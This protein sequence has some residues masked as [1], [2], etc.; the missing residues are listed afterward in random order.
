MTAEDRSDR[1]GAEPRSISTILLERVCARQPEA[2]QRL[3]H[4]YAPVVH[5]W[6]RELGV[7]PT[8]VADV[9]QD[10]FAGVLAD[11]GRFRR[12]RPSDSFGAWLR[13]ITRRRVIDHF[14]RGSDEA[15]AAGGTDAYRRMLSVPESEDGSS[16]ARTA[17]AEPEFLRGVLEMVRIDFKPPTW[18]MFWQTVVEGR[19]ADVVAASLGVSRAAVYQAKSR[20]LRQVRRV[21]AELPDGPGP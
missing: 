8:D 5:R 20:V 15:D 1:G 10:V 18:D 11:M 21:L 4:L 2:W 7:R 19:P 13:T 17:L 6:C 3:V 12:E 14:R 9:V 16:A